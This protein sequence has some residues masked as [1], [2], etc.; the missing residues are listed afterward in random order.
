MIPWPGER[1]K[2]P[3]KL[4]RSRGGSREHVHGDSSCFAKFCGLRAP[5]ATEDAPSLEDHPWRPGVV[6]SRVRSM[7]LCRK[8][9]QGDFSSLLSCRAKTPMCVSYQFLQSFQDFKRSKRRTHAQ[10]RNSKIRAWRP[11]KW[12]P[13]ASGYPKSSSGG[14]GRAGK[15]AKSA[16]CT[17]IIFWTFVY[18][19]NMAPFSV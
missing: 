7:K 2:I 5:G 8:Q 12:S 9:V 18:L 19:S 17:E 15:R 6:L 10:R 16:L 11:P 14:Q 13:G 4:E 1:S 3:T